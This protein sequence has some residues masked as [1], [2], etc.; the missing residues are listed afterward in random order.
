MLGFPVE[1]HTLLA[2]VEIKELLL[3]GEVVELRLAPEGPK[4]FFQVELLALPAEFYLLPAAAPLESVGSQ[5]NRPQLAGVILGPPP[6]LHGPL[7]GEIL[8]QP[9]LI[10]IHQGQMIVAGG[11]GRGRPG[12]LIAHGPLLHRA[13]NLGLADPIGQQPVNLLAHPGAVG[14]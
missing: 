10:L 2:N 14:A 8:R 9:G 13:G 7:R 12:V 11:I 1:G 4:F 3:H 5:R 6:V